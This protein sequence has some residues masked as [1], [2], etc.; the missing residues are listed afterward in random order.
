MAKHYVRLPNR[1]QKFIDTLYEIYYKYKDKSFEIIMSQYHHSTDLTAEEQEYLNTMIPEYANNISFNRISDAGPPQHTHIDRG[2]KS[3]L[4]VPVVAHPDVHKVYV[5][6]DEEYLDKL[7]ASDTG[8]FHNKEYIEQWKN[9]RYPGMPMFHDYDE[10][11]FDINPVEAGIP[12]INSTDLPHGGIHYKGMNTG[13]KYNRWFFSF[14]IPARKEV[15]ELKE[16]F[17]DWL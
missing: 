16:V 4:Q 7:T 12:Y 3:A 13:P 9:Q 10:Q 5:I 14:S 8:G 15:H 2:R 17:K 1:P 11:Y 6:K